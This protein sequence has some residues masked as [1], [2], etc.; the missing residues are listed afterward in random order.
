M[1]S[2]LFVGGVSGVGKSTLLDQLPGRGDE[3][4]R[5]SASRLIREELGL[6]SL[7]IRYEADVQRYQDALLSAYRRLS[8]VF[9]LPAVMDG[10][11][12]VAMPDGP[13]KLPEFVFEG[14]A[15]RL[16]VVLS[17]HAETVLK[18]RLERDQE[19]PSLRNIEALIEAEREA[20]LATAKQ[21]GVPLHELAASPSSL[22]PLSS[23]VKGLKL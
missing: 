14:L 3:W 15:P 16:L 6:A 13:R 17:S 7:P 5:L 1:G 21:L 23:L 2:L 20:A 19:A 9:D 12:T 18:Q 22:A 11:F 8:I 10:H 4:I